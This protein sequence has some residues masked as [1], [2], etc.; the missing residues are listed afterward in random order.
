M[1][2]FSQPSRRCAAF[3]LLEVIVVV[4]VILILISM[5]VPLV[6]EARRRAQA[7][8]C[9][10]RCRENATE[11]L[12]FALQHREALPVAVPIGSPKYHWNDNLFNDDVIWPAF[13]DRGPRSK[14][15]RCPGYSS[16]RH[17][18]NQAELAVDYRVSSAFFFDPSLYAEGNDEYVVEPVSIFQRPQRLS[19]VVF[20]SQKSLVFEQS[21]WHGLRPSYIRPEV[22]PYGLDIHMTDARGSAAFTDGHAALLHPI[23]DKVRWMRLRGYVSN[24]AFQSTPGGVRGADIP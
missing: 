24:G 20:P 14:Q 19:N 17:G 8:A 22:S 12:S 10:V 6:T 13:T 7:G 3:T 23:E 4:S 15:Y 11:L 2:A 16:K 1:H 21:I 5:L 18:N 9:L